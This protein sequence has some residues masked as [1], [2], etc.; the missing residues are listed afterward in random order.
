[1]IQ[2]VDAGVVYARIYKSGRDV[3]KKFKKQF[4]GETRLHN[5]QHRVP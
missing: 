1:M 3:L 5:I 2:K 4:R